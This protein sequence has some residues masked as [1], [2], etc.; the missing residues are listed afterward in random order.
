M[1]KYTF[2]GLELTGPN[3]P[4]PYLVRFYGNNYLV[5]LVYNHVAMKSPYF[6]I[7]D[8]LNENEKV[9]QYDNPNIDN[10]DILLIIKCINI[11]KS[12]LTY[13][14]NYLQK[15][16]QKENIRYNPY[17]NFSVSGYFG[18]FWAKNGK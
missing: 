11:V 18:G 7:E 10:N 5:P 12:N 4:I 15:K 6:L 17:V 1:K 8:N 14:Y 3:N 9:Q 2:S 16:Y 13:N